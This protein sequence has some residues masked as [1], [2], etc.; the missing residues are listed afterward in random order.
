[1]QKG[2]YMY[3]IIFIVILAISLI[4]FKVYRDIEKSKEEQEIQDNILRAQS[5]IINSVIFDSIKELN[6]DLTESQQ[7]DSKNSAFIRLLHETYFDKEEIKNDK[8]NQ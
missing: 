5:S 3:Q 2:G 6:L 1:M 7:S 8:G 4:G